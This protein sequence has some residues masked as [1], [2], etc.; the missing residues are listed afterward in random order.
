MKTNILTL[1]YFISAI[2]IV[3]ALTIISLLII[4][5]NDNIQRNKLLDNAHIISAAIDID[6]LKSL[7][8]GKS[9]LNTPFNQ[10]L[11]KQ[12][13]NIRTSNDSYKFLYLL[14][15]KEDKETVFFIIDSQSPNSP[16]YVPH[17]EIY[18]EVSDEFIAV[19]K[20]KKK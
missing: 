18:S 16:D 7:T 9:D 5:N 10:R 20:T 19:F 14:G 8:D 13:V 17:G 4:K 1:K 12:F 3:F 11:K 2:I 6:G 15:I